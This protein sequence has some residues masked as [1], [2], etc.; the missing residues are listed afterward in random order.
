[1]CRK[2]RNGLRCLPHDIGCGV[3]AVSSLIRAALGALRLLASSA[4]RYSFSLILLLGVSSAHAVYVDRGPTLYNVD[5]PTLGMDAACSNLAAY[6]GSGY[7]GAK[8]GGPDRAQQDM[9]E[10]TIYYPASA[11]GG[12]RTKDYPKRLICPSGGTV[13]NVGGDWRCMSWES[14]CPADTHVMEGGNCVPKPPGPE[15][16]SSGEFWDA[17]SKSCKPHVC[18]TADRWPFVNYPG[19]AGL[20]ECISTPHG[21]CI[22]D[23]VIVATPTGSRSVWQGTGKKC[24]D[25]TEPKPAPSDGSDDDA[26][27][28]GQLVCP[29]KGDG[30]CKSGYTKGTIAGVASCVK[31]TSDT[32]TEGKTE[33]AADGSQSKTTIKTETKCEGNTCVTTTTTAKENADGSSTTTGTSTKSESRDAYCA[34]NPRSTQCG[35]SESA[36]GGSCSAGFTCSGDPVQCAQARAAWG[37]K[38]AF[39][40]DP[41][42][43]VVSEGRSAVAGTGSPVGDRQTFSVAAAI[44]GR[45]YGPTSG[46]LSDES[47][48]LLGREITIPWSK[49]CPYLNMLGWGGNAVTFVYAML[50][51]FGRRS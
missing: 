34:Q 23:Q 33:T 5:P 25:G 22:F 4:A 38:C 48:Y 45:A 9:I 39:D 50:L 18:S 10:C 32:K 11:G 27:Q 13:Q 30:T 26:E 14:E 6:Y 43:S 36:W 37:Q 47:I 8:T 19:G 17:A 1:M 49:L 51:V 15:S 12:V 20:S 7:T 16:C 29:P 28:C 21:A 35:D 24:S 31:N 2:V 44:Q 46:C 41:Q 40:V 3:G 42:H